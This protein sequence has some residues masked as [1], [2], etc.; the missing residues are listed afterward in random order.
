[1]KAA[2]IYTK[3][4]V[5]IIDTAKQKRIN[6][7]SG[8]LYITK[9]HAFVF[10][11]AHVISDPEHIYEIE[12]FCRRD[13]VNAAELEQ[14]RYRV[15]GS[16]FVKHMDYQAAEDRKIFNKNDVAGIQLEK[17]SWMEGLPAIQFTVPVPGQKICYSGYPVKKWDESI[18]FAEK[19]CHS[20]IQIT[21]S[22]E[23]RLQFAY[24][25][26][27]DWSSMGDVVEGFSGSGV[28]ADVEECEI[29]LL[30]GIL[31]CGQGANLP[32][33]AVNAIS[34][35]AIKDLCDD[36][37]WPSPRYAAEGDAVPR[38]EQEHIAA[39][40]ENKLIQLLSK[41]VRQKINEMR[42]LI[43][44]MKIEEALGLYDAF[45]QTAAYHTA[46]ENDKCFLLFFKVRCHFLL[47]DM[48]TA[49]VLLEE[50]ITFDV[51]ER[52]W[53]LV[54]KANIL[55]NRMG[56]PDGAALL[57]QADKLLDEAI[58]LGIKDSKAKIFKRYIEALKSQSSLDEKLA[59]VH[60]IAA[61]E[62]MDLNGFQ[63]LYSVQGTLCAQAS[64]FEKAAEYF[65]TAYS[66]QGDECF[67][68]QSAQMYLALASQNSPENNLFWMAKAS[69]NFVKY[70]ENCGDALTQAFYRELGASF[71]DCAMTLGQYGLIM[72]HIDGVIAQT[73][74]PDAVQRMYLMKA[75]VQIELEEPAYETLKHLGLPDQQALFLHMEFK[76]TMSQYTQLLEDASVCGVDARAGIESA[77]RAL[78]R[79]QTMLEEKRRL[80]QLAVEKIDAFLSSQDSVI[81][82]GIRCG[83]CSD[84]I[85]GLL[86]SRNGD[87]YEAAIKQFQVLFPDQED[88]H[89]INRLLLP[90]VCGEP[91][92]TE[93]LLLKYVSRNR[94]PQR[95]QCILN[96]YFRN[97]DY[98]GLI[99][100]Y[101][102]LVED[103][104]GLGQFARSQL[105]WAYLDYLTKPNCMAQKA[106]EQYLRYKEHLLNENL[107]SIL[108]MR[109]NHRCYHY[110]E[111]DKWMRDADYWIN[112]THH[113][114]EYRDAILMSTYN[115]KKEAAEYYYNDYVNHCFPTLS[116]EEQRK[117]CPGWMWPYFALTAPGEEAGT[118]AWIINENLENAL[119]NVR[120]R[121]PEDFD[122]WK[123]L[124]SMEEKTIVIDGPSMYY[125]SKHDLLQNV[126]HAADKVIITYSTIGWYLGNERYFC[127]PV[128]E[129]IFR[130]IRSD[131]RV[132]LSEA[133]LDSQYVF[134]EDF[135]GDGWYIKGSHCLAKEKNI[136]VVGAYH[137]HEGML[138]E[139]K[140]LLIWAGDFIGSIT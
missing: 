44:S 81:D 76:G 121:N 83:L 134:R 28:Y 79:Y 125:L 2:D 120:N 77:K 32:H 26:Y 74:N 36:Q 89:E 80:I 110:T 128:I 48:E 67:L 129:A 50:G 116:R 101:E 86:N 98:N 23:K 71:L 123:L 57:E 41:E 118:A 93:L 60:E 54:E 72:K 29:P 11:A 61:D 46:S 40:N 117:Q 39:S 131:E 94:N 107:C 124:R 17:R 84:R 113:E 62:Y 13:E 6:S 135:G 47:G 55:M 1:M 78:E 106:L 103:A 24:Q 109:L 8:F 139:M 88:A 130:W 51:P 52:Y 53:H 69:D 138:E 112:E 63:H 12:C 59:Y 43:R 85:N 119:R 99:E 91:E 136:P 75:I 45:V 87:K 22:S 27:A 100:F 14:Y 16:A 9:D 7:G 126:F 42:S 20:D 21:S 140:P 56:L 127:D 68:I 132:V 97:Q 65:N 105:I 90:E 37:S 30:V 49:E 34:F 33:G 104:D 82:Q 73:Q 95:M 4:S 58:S 92:K 108:K 19:F 137:N 15:E 64:Q 133:C 5:R 25:E 31:T 66:F 96:F 102:G 18:E 38:P 35:S 111:Y 3:L 114:S 115:L 122:G 10:T 70:L